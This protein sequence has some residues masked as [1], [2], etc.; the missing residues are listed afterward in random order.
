MA[1]PSPRSARRPSSPCPRSSS[2]K[3]S[4]T[5][6]PPSQTA[7]R[8][9]NASPSG[10]VQRRPAR[11][12]VRSRAPACAAPPRPRAEARA[13]FTARSHRPR[14][15]PLRLP[16]VGPDIHVAANAHVQDRARRLRP[17]REAA[18]FNP[19]AAAIC[20]QPHHARVCRSSDPAVLT[21]I[22]TTDEHS[23]QHAHP[24]YSARAPPWESHDYALQ[25]P[26]FGS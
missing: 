10:P 5:H 24:M 8:P 25:I 20:R 15:A 14:R 2:P 4:H 7:P 13:P 11:F 19:E 17:A 22:A 9:R 6:T 21:P 16:A 23:L 26:C 1:P 3:V 18:R 12:P